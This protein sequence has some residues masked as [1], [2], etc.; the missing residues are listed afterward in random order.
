MAVRRQFGIKKD[1]TVGGSALSDLVSAAIPDADDLWPVQTAN[2]DKNTSHLDRNDEVTGF[3]GNPAPEEFR[4]DPRVNV[5]G[6]AYS[7]LLEILWFYALG[8]PDVVSGAAPAA[9]THLG[10]PVG[11]GAGALPALHAHIVRDGQTDKVSGCY[12]NQITSAFTLDGHGTFEAE[13]WGLFHA[14]LNNPTVPTLARHARDIK[15]FKLRDLKAY[16]GGS[17]TPVPGVT[18][19]SITYNN[20]IVDDSDARFQAGSEIHELA[21]PGGAVRRIWYPTEH[22]LG[23]SQAITGEINFASVKQA[24]D[25]KHDLAYAEAIVAEVEGVSIATTPAAKELMRFSVLNAVRSGGGAEEMQKEG[26]QKS[27]Y[28]FGGYLDGSG[29]DLKVESVNNVATAITT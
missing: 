24:E 3:R 21:D 18:G 6:L 25:V 11:Y 20:N 22:F 13:L 9:R 28:Q 4:K 1:A 7:R 27:S 17:P 5:K 8:G 23:G 16:F 14:A 26:V 2:V 12:V 29:A 10:K 15:T 19:F